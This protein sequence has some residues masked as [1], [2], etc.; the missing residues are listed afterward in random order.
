[1]RR[2]AVPGRGTPCDRHRPQ[3]AAYP[4]DVGGIG[5]HA[6]EATDVLP[7]TVGSIR[8]T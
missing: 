8:G 2:G 3:G 4:F 7:G 6:S 5:L 1:V